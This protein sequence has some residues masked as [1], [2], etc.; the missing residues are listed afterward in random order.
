MGHDISPFTYLASLAALTLTVTWAIR[1]GSFKPWKPRRWLALLVTPMALIVSL[2]LHSTADTNDLMVILWNMGFV[3]L[4]SAAFLAAQV[5]GWG[6]QMDLGRNDR[7]DDE[8]FYQVRDWFFESKSSFGRDLM[9]LYMRFAQFIVPGAIWFLV[10][11][12][13]FIIGWAMFLFAPLWWVVEYVVWWNKGK[14][15][16]FAFVEYVI[17]GML[18]VTV[19]VLIWL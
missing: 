7:P 2:G 3:T 9:G 1:G 12:W 8:L 14:Q 15:P 4:G 13:Y 16:G 17:G 11:P 5:M 6:R 18:A 19:L 10:D